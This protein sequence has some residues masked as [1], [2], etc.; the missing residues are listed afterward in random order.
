[1][2]DGPGEKPPLLLLLLL[3]LLLGMRRLHFA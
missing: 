3:L 2:A 1:M